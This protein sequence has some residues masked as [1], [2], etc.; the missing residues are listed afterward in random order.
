[1]D[2]ILK[3]LE[4]VEDFT[5]NGQPLSKASGAH[6][7]KRMALLQ[8]P[9]RKNKVTSVDRMRRMGTRRPVLD[10]GSEITREE[11]QHFMSTAQESLLPQA[12]RVKESM[13]VLWQ[14]REEEYSDYNRLAKGKEG[15]APVRATMQAMSPRSKNRLNRLPP[16]S[17]LDEEKIEA[18]MKDVVGSEVQRNQEH[19][20]N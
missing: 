19:K 20:R 11:K 15:E 2:D 13:Q 5:R 9:E 1:M 8:E 12:S 16:P 17:S 4:D 14:P 6:L 18:F 10:A 7:T 3:L